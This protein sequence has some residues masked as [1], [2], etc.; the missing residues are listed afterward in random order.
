MSTPKL[1]TRDEFRERVKARD[2][3]RCVRCGRREDEVRLDAHHII[4]RRLWPDGGYYVENGATLCDDGSEQSCHML[5]ETTELTVEKIRELAGI[6]KKCLPEH[7]YDDVEYDKWGNV[8]LPNGQRMKGEL[9][10][11][12]SVQKV[13]KGS[14]PLFT[15]YVKYPRTYHLPWSP[16]VGK[17]DRVMDYVKNPFART[18]NGMGLPIAGLAVV[19]T[20][21]MDGEN[22]TMYRDYIHARSI[23]GRNHPSRNWVKGLHARIK[24]E[25]PD[26]WRICGENLYAKHSIQYDSL[27]SYFI[28]FSIWNDKNECL[29]W[30]ETKEWAQLLEL[31]T[32]RELYVGIFDDDKIKPLMLPEKEPEGVE[33]YVV[34]SYTSFP[35]H[36]F[37]FKVAKYV[38]RNHVQTH[39]HWMREVMQVN[40]LKSD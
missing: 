3:H 13:I 12:E 32:P 7:L 15:S 21:K 36:A 2:N 19:V 1:L 6:T 4:E 18:K 10:A 22:T 30:E 31:P 23:D 26:G 17:D 20:E 25:I 27:P 16:G 37:R 39:G 28:M 9:F 38:R 24:H 35:Y 8:I 40:G 5:A 33:G 14:L 11:D 29:G 34:R